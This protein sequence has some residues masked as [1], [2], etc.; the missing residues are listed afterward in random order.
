MGGSGLVTVE[1]RLEDC[2]GLGRPSAPYSVPRK[3]L[4][5]AIHFFSYHL[6][7][8]RRSTRRARAAGFRLVVRPTVFHPRYFLT[9]ELFARFIDRLDLRDKCVAEVGTGSGVLALAA[10]R[11]GARQVVAIDINPNA[12]F[13]AAE[14]ARLNGLGDRVFPVCSNLLS[15]IAPR[16]LFDVILSSPPSF[17]GEPRDVADRAWH[18]GPGYRD[19]AAVFDQ[20]RERLKPGGRFYVLLSSDSDLGLLG[21][22]IARAGLDAKLVK[23]R[24]IGFESFVLYELRAA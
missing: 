19:I 13:S 5:D 16:P 21:R 10:A 22:L 11:A 4:R 8:A 20:A 23:Q 24:S 15:G 17:S 7:L 6:I 12:A 9:S 1:K 2:G 14:N 3:L 18:A